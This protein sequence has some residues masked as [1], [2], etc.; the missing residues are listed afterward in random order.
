[1][2]ITPY[3]KNAKK[4]P[5]KQIEQIANS[6]RE[7][8]MHQDIVVDK[9]GVIIVG[10]GRYA[11]LQ[12]LGWSNE[13]IMKHVRVA[14]L[15][16][17]QAKSYRLADNK[18]NESDWEMEL[19][20]E[21]LKQLSDPLI[22]LTGFDKDLILEPDEKD[23]EVPETAPANSSLGDIYEL[24]G[25]KII[26]GDSTDKETYAKLMGGR[27][28]DM[29]F[30]DPPYNVDYK[31][32]GKNTKEGIMNDKME[33]EQFN[34]FLTEAFKRIAE[35]VKRSAGCYIFHSHK[36][37]SQFEKTLED[38]GFTIDTQ[39]IW[40]KPSAGMGMNHY[41]T[42]H[43][44][45]FY[46][47]LEK[48]KDWYGDRTGTTV[49]KVP[50]D[51]LKALKWLQQQEQLLESG[52][53]TVWT[54][55]RAPVNEY[56]HPTQKPVELV[57]TALVKSSKTD[58]IILDPFLGSGTTLIACEKAQRLCYGIELDSKYVDTIIQRWVDYTGI[59]EIKKNGQDIIWEKTQASVD[60]E[61][62]D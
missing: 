51:P 29:V 15:T 61:L 39:L 19:V 42:K 62:D 22:E 17:E 10:H 58:D 6:I 25:H 48:E 16:P 45:F 50:E 28:A 7:F 4:H 18:L 35:N 30:T 14:D 26:C 2:N 12:L 8:G 54:M 31:G 57:V 41:R 32:K 34:L 23:D 11:A 13:E 56:V 40:N 20:I 52:G 53:S 36:T 55:K 59:E 49:W 46:C 43:E 27:P 33:D 9:E 5:K 21:E 24:G 3:T 47:S 44:P 37:A 1:M 38:S 60:P